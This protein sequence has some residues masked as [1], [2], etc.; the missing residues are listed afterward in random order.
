MT[1][2]AQPDF[3]ATIRPHLSEMRRCAFSLAKNDADA[4]D[5]VQEMLLRAFRFWNT[6]EAPADR[7]NDPRPWLQCLLVRV[8]CDGYRKARDRKRAL[9][10]HMASSPDDGIAVARNFALKLGLQ[11]EYA[12]ALPPQYGT[13]SDELMSALESLDPNWRTALEAHMDGETRE[14]IATR[15]HVPRGTVMSRVTRARRAVGRMRS[16]VELA[17]REYGMRAELPDYNDPYE[18]APGVRRRKAS[19]ASASAAVPA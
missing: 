18:N 12:M 8:Y 1:K 13:F 14:E 4:D 7:P 16:I 6:W 15:L 19:H 2:P 3:N 11:A 17:Q 10:S 5:L 9:A